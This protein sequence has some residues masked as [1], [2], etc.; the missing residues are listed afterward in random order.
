MVWQRRGACPACEYRVQCLRPPRLPGHESRPR[1][2]S[3]T[4]DAGAGAGVLDLVVTERAITDKI[5]SNAI[6]KTLPTQNF[7]KKGPI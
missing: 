6:P 7:S 1:S 4:P 3:S 2:F 5:Q